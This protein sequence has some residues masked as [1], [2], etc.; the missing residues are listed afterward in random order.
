MPFVETSNGRDSTRWIER[1]ILAAVITGAAAWG[2]HVNDRASKTEIVVAA[3]AA[4][5]DGKIEVLNERIGYTN[6]T[7]ARIE[8]ALKEKP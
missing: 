4:R 2:W 6:Q 1:T 8:Q 3:L 5:V 7:L